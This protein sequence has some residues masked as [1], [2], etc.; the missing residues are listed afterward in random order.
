MLPTAVGRHRGAERAPNYIRN[1]HSQ[2]S[3][4]ACGDGSVSDSSDIGARVSVFIWIASFGALRNRSSKG[5]CGSPRS[6]KRDWCPPLKKYEYLWR[7][8]QKRVSL[9]AGHTAWV[10]VADPAVW[11]DFYGGKTF[12]RE[13]YSLFTQLSA[14][15]ATHQARI[16]GVFSATALAE[17]RGTCHD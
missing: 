16:A 15:P 2:R 9:P 7:R 17:W 5:G 3:E 14:P 6:P 13:G 4:S 11:L 12:A 1:A 10:I 8:C